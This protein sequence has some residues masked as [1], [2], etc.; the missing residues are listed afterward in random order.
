M[1]TLDLEKFDPNA[2]ALTALATAYKDLAIAGP[3]DKEGY[4]V[5]HAARLHLRDKRVLITKTGKAL[6]EEATAFAKKVIEK[7]KEL[8]AIVEPVE[9]ALQERQ[10]AVD[11]EI[12]KR[13]RV[14]LLP[15][16]R[17]KCQSIELEASDDLLLSM[18]P[19]Q[20]AD[21][22][23]GKKE[24]YLNAKEDA[25]RIER[26]RI[27]HDAQLV[28]EERAREDRAREK[29]KLAEQREKDRLAELEKAKAEAA[30]TERQRIEREAREKAERK[31]QEAKAKAEAD[32]QA[33]ADLESRKKYQNWLKKHGVTEAFPTH[34][35][36]DAE[37]PPE[38]LIVESSNSR[39]SVYKLVDTMTL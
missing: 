28:L 6:R 3:D 26:E 37:K 7:E 18:D 15:D 14:A 38:N 8:I 12:E 35:R 5:V 2:P 25:L 1:E 36:S 20:F 39:Y 22:F 16:R 9:I 10:D 17:T 23:N 13:K 33:R 31:E 32:A 19:A 11:A 34:V 29:A 4:Q 27:E 30:A 21:F 24:A